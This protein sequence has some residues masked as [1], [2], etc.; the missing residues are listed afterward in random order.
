MVHGT[1][2]YRPN[3]VVS[4]CYSKFHTAVKSALVSLASHVAREDLR[5]SVD[6]LVAP[7][8]SAKTGG[9]SCSPRSENDDA[10]IKIQNSFGGLPVSLNCQTTRNSPTNGPNENVKTRIIF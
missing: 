9:V 4:S 6:Q 10:L 8:V 3:V 2:I 7:K 1:L 5:T